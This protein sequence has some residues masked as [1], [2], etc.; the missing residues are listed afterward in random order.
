MT[1]KNDL[2]KDIEETRKRFHQLL[3]SIPESEYARQSGN[4]AWTVG[5]VLYHVT[6][7]PRAIVFEVWM[8]VHARGLYQ[9]GM[10]HF[11]S[12]WFNR[13]NAW[14][15]RREPR[16]L[17]RAGLGNAYENAHTALRSALRR[18]REQDFAR[19]VVYPAELVAE[20]AGKVSVERLF[21]YTKW[22]FEVHEGQIQQR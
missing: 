4:A 1:L 8:I 6:L 16:Q 12:R 7:G 13:V 19:S 15:G 17:S 22:H 9:F 21:R 3:D 10:L 18:T 14:F 2:F 20:L 11:P 5:N